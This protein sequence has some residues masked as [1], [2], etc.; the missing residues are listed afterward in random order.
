VHRLHSVI[1]ELD[2]SQFRTKGRKAIGLVFAG[3][4]IELALTAGGSID[5]I[6]VSTRPGAGGF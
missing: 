5:L 1:F 3:W 2:V 4:T 6:V